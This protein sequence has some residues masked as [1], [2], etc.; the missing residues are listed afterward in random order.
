[1]RYD[2]SVASISEKTVE[3]STSSAATC[4]ATL[5]RSARP[6]SSWDQATSVEKE[7]EENEVNVIPII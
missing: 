5:T 4:L 1:M 2:L 7:Y 3:S 6:D